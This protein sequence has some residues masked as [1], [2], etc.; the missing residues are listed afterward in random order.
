MS[1]LTT[2]PA[3]RW[4]DHLRRHGPKDPETLETLIALAAFADIDGR[5]GYVDDAGELVSVRMAPCRA[6][7]LGLDS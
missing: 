7:G 4:T 1:C 2:T 5:T 6:C 3:E